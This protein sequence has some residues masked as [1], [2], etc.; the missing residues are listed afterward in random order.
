MKH[1]V[2]YSEYMKEKQH[3]KKVGKARKICMYTLVAV[4]S[5]QGAQMYSMAS[6]QELF[7]KYTNMKV[8]AFEPKKYTNVEIEETNGTEY[9]VDDDGNVSRKDGTGEKEACFTN[10][11]DN[12]TYE[13][14]R[15]RIVAV[16]KTADGNDVEGMEVKYSIKHEKDADWQKE[17]NYYYYKKPL[18]PGGKTTKFLKK[19]TIDK[20][21]LTSVNLKSKGQYI[22]LSVI[23]DSVETDK[24]G[25]KTKAI[26]AWGNSVESILQQP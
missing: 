23:V 13:Y 8:N 16:V 7:Q 6:F 24:N 9:T 20:D 5:M 18:E 14:V 2:Y 1:T 25:D 12:V 22:E 15:A 4:L 10:P 21:W 17:G 11:I 3:D 19:V 26:A